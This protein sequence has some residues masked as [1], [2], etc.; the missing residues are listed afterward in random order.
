MHKLSQ[1]KFWPSQVIHA[2][3]P[4]YTSDFNE[5]INI[6]VFLLFV[7]HT[8]VLLYLHTCTSFHIFYNEL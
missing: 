6:V 7:P 2:V 3:C 4:F 5:L 8:S 1:V